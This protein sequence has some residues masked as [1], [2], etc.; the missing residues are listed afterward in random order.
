MRQAR[1][2]ACATLLGL[3][4][5]AAGSAAGAGIKAEP[6]KRTD[7]MQL[8]KGG[9]EI[10]SPS[11]VGSG[12]L[13]SEDG[14]WPSAPMTVRLKGFREIEHFRASA[15][16]LTFLCEIERAGGVS[17]TRQC[18]LGDKAAGEVR[19]ADNGFVLTIPAELFA[20]AEEG[21]VLEWVDRWR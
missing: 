9:L 17:T 3:A 4:L 14:T 21:V 18:R 8:R 20:R 16:A 11:G 2:A 5:C 19:L 15:G 13:L 7:S 12:Q 6:A 10:L 1:L